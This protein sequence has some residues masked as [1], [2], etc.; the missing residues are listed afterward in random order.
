M[1]TGPKGSISARLAATTRILVVED[2]L[3]IAEFLR[4]YFRA[5]GYQL[6]H[7]DPDSAEAA[8]EAARSLAPSVIL[9]DVALRGFSGL[10]VYRLLLSDEAF[11][12]VPIILVTADTS[13][14]LRS[15]GV[16]RPID[17]HVAKPFSIGALAGLVRD[18]LAAAS[19]GP[20]VQG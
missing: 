4:A 18:L 6:D 8:L 7:V 11:D 17:G 10:D 12:R 20:G 1:V 16:A 14:R 19:A 2:T 9:L 13:A 15:V 3:E 5:N